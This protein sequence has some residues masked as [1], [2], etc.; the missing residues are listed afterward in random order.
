[1]RA[2]SHSNASGLISSAQ[3]ALADWVLKN[4]ARRSRPRAVKYVLTR[5]QYRVYKRIRSFLAMR[6][7]L[8]RAKGRIPPRTMRLSH[9]T[10]RFR[11]KQTKKRLT[12]VR[13]QRRRRA[14]LVSVSP[15]LKTFLDATR[16]P[17]VNFDDLVA[18]F[19]CQGIR[20]IAFALRRIVMQEY[21]AAA[22]R[23]KQ[24]PSATH[25]DEHAQGHANTAG[26]QH[27]HDR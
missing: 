15:Q 14:A 8:L 7:R 23:A 4:T 20:G 9:I 1:M 21:G 16:A 17:T 18:F 22:D 12:R 24:M 26:L 27:E 5:A 25:P 6:R 19:G 13:K 3:S 2:R 11:W 10:G